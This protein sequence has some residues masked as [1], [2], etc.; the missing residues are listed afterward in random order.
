MKKTARFFGFVAVVLAGLS[1]ARLHA[2]LMLTNGLVAYYPFSG[3]A[4]DA[5]GNG[6][7]GTPIGITYTTNRFG[8]ATNAILLNGSSS[9]V[10]ISYN[11][12]F[13]FAPT[14]QFTLSAWFKLNG[15]GSGS[16]GIG[17]LVVKG[18]SNGTW[19]Y[20]LECPYFEQYI[21][22]A[23]MASQY[24]CMS[25][26][27]LQLGRWY[28]GAM[29]YSNAF[30]RLYLN[31][32]LLVSSNT[33]YKITQSTGGIAIGRKGDSSGDYFN[34]AIDDVRIYNRALS[35]IEIQMLYQYEAGGPQLCGAAVVLQLSTTNLMV[36]GS[37]Q[38]QV[39]TNLVTWQNY[40]TPFLATATNAPQYVNMTSPS[41]FFR[42]LAAP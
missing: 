17:S 25:T 38:I 35:T 14:G 12:N 6:L 1:S 15:L 36:G 34:G 37:Y 27:V 16:G 32:S 13:N 7:N 42:I 20:G 10:G 22:W 18:I 40:G 8:L 11:T 26:N 29:T 2:Q 23:G 30:W 41:G 31:G 24:P 39:S 33:S 21:L 28:N 4:N 3:N 19:D 9:Y 5:S